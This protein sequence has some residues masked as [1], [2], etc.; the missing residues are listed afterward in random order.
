MDIRAVARVCHEA[1]R[2]LCEAYG[3]TSQKPWFEAADWQ[4]DSAVKGVQVALDGATPRQQHEAWCADKFSA[5]WVY[6]PVKDPD[7]KEHPCLVDYDALPIEQRVKDHVFG[8]IVRAMA[9]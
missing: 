1:N 5:G 9:G 6:G 3:D 4:R 8:A 2:A 7:L